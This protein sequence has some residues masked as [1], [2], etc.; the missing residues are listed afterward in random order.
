M[1]TSV[2][3][4]LDEYES[5]EQISGERRQE[6]FDA[7][8][9]AHQVLINDDLSQYSEDTQQVGIQAAERLTPY[10]SNMPNTGGR[11]DGAGSIVDGLGNTFTPIEP[12]DT[13]VGGSDDS[14]NYILG[15]CTGVNPNTGD[16]YDYSS[17]WAGAGVDPQ[18]NV[19][20]QTPGGDFVAPPEMDVTPLE[21]PS[22]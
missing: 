14:C 4:C 8:E 7:L 21:P 19:I 16:F 17:D 18:G 15:I 3:E 20:E 11:T 13:G 5:E 2:I 10:T 6:C 22:E 9:Q 12:S 1:F